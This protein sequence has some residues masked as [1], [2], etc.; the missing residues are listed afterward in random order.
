M[1]YLSNFK[2]YSNFNGKNIFLI[3]NQRYYT[4]KNITNY[5]KV[6]ESRSKGGI[7]LVEYALAYILENIDKAKNLLDVMN[8][9]SEETVLYNMANY[10]GEVAPNTPFDDEEIYEVKDFDIDYLISK[11]KGVTP[12]QLFSKT[13]DDDREYLKNIFTE[14]A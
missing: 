6:N 4:M 1:N 7:S 10:V 5:L 9:Y 14:K 13:T 8:D 3:K 11:M 2:N 12:K